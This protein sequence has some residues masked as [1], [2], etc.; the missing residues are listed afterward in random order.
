M[1]DETSVRGSWRIGE[2]EL[3][4]RDYLDMEVPAFLRLDAD[5]LGEFQFGLV[6]GQ[7]DYRVVRTGPGSRV[8]FSWSG[9]DEEDPVSGRGWGEVQND[10]LKGRIFIHLGN[11]SAFAA[12]RQ[13]QPGIVPR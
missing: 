12:A 3:W 5:G 9:F 1:T 8:E 4:D 11:D 7:I 10:R 2:M 13:S 6:R